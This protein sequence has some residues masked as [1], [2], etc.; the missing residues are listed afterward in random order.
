[1]HRVANGFTGVGAAIINTLGNELIDRR[2]CGR[3]SRIAKA[4]ARL[5]HD[6]E[7]QRIIAERGV[8]A[9]GNLVKRRDVH[10][11]DQ[12]DAVVHTLQIGILTDAQMR[13]FWPAS[14]NGEKRPSSAV[15][16]IRPRRFFS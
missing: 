3:P 6:S 11:T 2:Q 16:V 9:L 13:W 15:L 12:L 7:F 1:V 14:I 8:H 4:N 5:P 10:S